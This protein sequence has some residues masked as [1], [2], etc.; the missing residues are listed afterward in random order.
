MYGKR[1]E[2]KKTK[3]DFIR[4]MKIHLKNKIGTPYIWL[5]YKMQKMQL[6]PR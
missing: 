3:S 6:F 4:G 2:K 1:V 5:N